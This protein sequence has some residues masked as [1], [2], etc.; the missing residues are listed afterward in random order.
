M[1][2]LPIQASTVPCKCVFSSSAETD[3]KKCNYI[4]PT[5]MEVLQMLKFALKKEQLH[6][7]K[8]L[9]MMKWKMIHDEDTNNTLAPLT[10]T[11][12]CDNAMIW[13]IDP[14]TLTEGNTAP[15]YVQV[16]H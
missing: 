7:M 4:S 16:F 14:I 10:M 9:V 1:D 15:G 11:G 2:Y 8:Y 13:A 3:T 12:N 6:S 5:L